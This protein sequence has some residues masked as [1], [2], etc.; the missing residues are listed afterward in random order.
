MIWPATLVCLSR[1]RRQSRRSIPLLHSASRPCWRNGG[2]TT[3][4][5]AGCWLPMLCIVDTYAVNGGSII[6]CCSWW[7]KSTSNVRTWC[8][9]AVY[10]CPLK[11][12]GSS[13]Y[14]KY[15]VCSQTWVHSYLY[16]KD[17]TVECS[18][19]GMCSTDNYQPIR[20]TISY[21]ESPS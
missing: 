11:G 7:R 4:L 2:I 9:P 14:F 19:G 8:L 6:K 13:P 21:P 5:P 16:T 1:Y 10:P 15:L 20:V 18:R 17:W 12:E 3:P